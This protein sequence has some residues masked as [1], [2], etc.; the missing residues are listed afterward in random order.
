MART[1]YA[2]RSDLLGS[3]LLNLAHAW[4]FATVHGAP[5][6]CW[7]P[8]YHEQRGEL[9]FREIYL[10]PQGGD[11]FD[12]AEEM[13]VLP[14]N[15]VRVERLTSR[16]DIQTAENI[17]YAVTGAVLL[18]DESLEQAEAEA[19][20]LMRTLRV[21]PEIEQAMARIKSRIDLSAFVAVHI[22]RGDDVIRLI[23][24][25][26]PEQATRLI[27]GYVG[28]YADIESYRLAIEANTSDA[29][30]FVFSNS[31]TEI[32][33]LK[34]AMPDREVVSLDDLADCLKNFL[35][36]RPN[37]MGLGIQRDF[38]EQ[39]IMAEARCIVGPNSNFST[40]ARLMGSKPVVM[41]ARW[42]NPLTMIAHVKRDF[43]DQSVFTRII[44]SYARVM[45]KVGRPEAAATF[46]KSIDAS[47]I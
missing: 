39:M 35:P 34:S 47:H 6:V 37:Q 33:S 44:K 18:A 27:E 11:P 43:S 25:T 28:R 12:L 1:I 21:R 7:W 13:P 22:R 36:A 31:A 38:I 4:R 32:A 41:V 24:E 9:P 19:R 8:N 42:L 30:L 46:L 26:P 17:C 45:L 16:S 15:Y 29:P 20:R 2:G 14:R 23:S 40:F 10:W 3:A 5:L